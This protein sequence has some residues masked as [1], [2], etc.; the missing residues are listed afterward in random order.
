MPMIAFTRAHD[1]LS[2]DCQCADKFGSASMEGGFARAL[3]GSK[4][5]ADDF[6]SALECG[7]PCS[8]G[9]KNKCA[10]RAVSINRI[11]NGNLERILVSYCEM[12]ATVRGLTREYDVYRYYAKLKFATDSGR[13]WDYPESQRHIGHV[14]FWKADSFSLSDVTVVEI[15]PLYGE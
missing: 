9:C 12:R 14:N 5:E 7:E 8:S 13:M 11:E 6:M 10:H 4:F 3:V 1:G 2:A 15:F